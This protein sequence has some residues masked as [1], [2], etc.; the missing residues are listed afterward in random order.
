[1]ESP[2]HSK[3]WVEE[4]CSLSDHLSFSFQYIVREPNMVADALARDG[5]SRT[6][7]AFDI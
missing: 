7:L 1:M 3:D 6:Y 2:R 4:I 5:A